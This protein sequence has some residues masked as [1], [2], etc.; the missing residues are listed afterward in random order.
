MK[1]Y[2]QPPR[3]S[4]WKSKPANNWFKKSV[5]RVKAG[6]IPARCRRP[7]S[8]FPSLANG[9]W[10]AKVSEFAATGWLKILFR[11]STFF[12]KYAKSPR[13]KPIIQTCMSKATEMSGSRFG[14]TRSVDLAKT[15]LSWPPKL[16]RSRW[17]LPSALAQLNFR[18][19]PLWHDSPSREFTSRRLVPLNRNP[20]FHPW[21]TT[22]A[23]C[24]FTWALAARPAFQFQ[25]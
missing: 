1:S 21:Q 12:R 25:W 2:L 24:Q 11:P 7:N 22:S 15:I 17:R 14:P 20:N 23:S 16:M 4:M 5:F 10:L 6:S 8:N 18:V 13:P 3:G 9:S 19:G